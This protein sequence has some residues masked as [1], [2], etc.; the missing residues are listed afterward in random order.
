MF[1][2][3]GKMGTAISNGQVGCFIRHR[4]RE[5]GVVV[6]DHGNCY[7]DERFFEIKI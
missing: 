7:G 3:T 5:V 6:S 1:A 2:L 4:A